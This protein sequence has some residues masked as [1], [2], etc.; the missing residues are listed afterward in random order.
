[1]ICRMSSHQKPHPEAVKRLVRCPENLELAAILAVG[2][3][4]EILSSSQEERPSWVL[5]W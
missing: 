4:A 5:R 1:M 3:P 2:Y